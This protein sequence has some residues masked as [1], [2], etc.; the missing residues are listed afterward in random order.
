MRE[1]EREP[2]AMSEQQESGAE[3]EQQSSEQVTEQQTTEPAGGEE[4]GSTPHLVSSFG[5]H[6]LHPTVYQPT[7]PAK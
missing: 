6:R 3:P 7:E 5:G 1:T 4:Q 2:A